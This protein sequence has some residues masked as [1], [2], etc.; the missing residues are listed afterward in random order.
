MKLVT[1]DKVLS[2]SCNC[3]ICLLSLFQLHLLHEEIYCGRSSVG[4]SMH[5]APHA[6]II[7]VGD[8]LYRALYARLAAPDLLT[9]SKLPLMV[10]TLFKV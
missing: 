3:R 10:S 4:L 1:I 2:H 8:R 6:E 9:S 7:P 5:L